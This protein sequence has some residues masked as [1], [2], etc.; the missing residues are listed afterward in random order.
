MTVLRGGDSS[1]VG[2]YVDFCQI[3]D[4][5]RKLHG[6]TKT[7]IQETMRICQEK[8]ILTPFLLSRRK[9]VIDIMEMLFTQEEVWEMCKREIARNAEQ[10]GRKEGAESR[11]I[12]YG[13]LL[14]QLEPLGRIGDLLA[15]IADKEKLTSLAQ[16]FGLK[17]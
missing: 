11:D 14:R 2:Q 1:I 15:A 3:A 8:G 5:Q 7:A 12:L 10:E 13:E 17:M 16:E 4:E 9:E 6:Y